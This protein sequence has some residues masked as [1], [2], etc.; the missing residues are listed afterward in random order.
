[1]P[2]ELSGQVKLQAIFHHWVGYC[3]APCVDGAEAC[4]QQ[5]GRATGWV[6]LL[7]KV[8]SWA[9]QWEVPLS[10]L[11]GCPG[12]LFRLPGY[13]G[14]ENMLKNCAALLGGRMGSPGRLLAGEGLE[15]MVELQSRPA[16]GCARETF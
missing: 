8:V 12:S 14:T 16:I 1:M 15:A 4:A 11:G 6:P 7:G 9:L 13:V 2:S 10:G 3:L 5:S